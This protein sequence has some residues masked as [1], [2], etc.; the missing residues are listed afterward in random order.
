[1]SIVKKAFAISALSIA[2]L[3]LSANANATDA[4]ST[5]KA[6]ININVEKLDVPTMNISL[7]G[8]P[9]DVI[10]DFGAKK[11]ITIGGQ[12]LN[13]AMHHPAGSF[14]H[15]MMNVA[16]VSPNANHALKNAITNDEVKYDLYLSDAVGS[17]SKFKVYHGGTVS[18]PF[19]ASGSGDDVL[20]DASAFSNAGLS[21]FN[22]ILGGSTTGSVDILASTYVSLESE[23]TTVADGV[24]ADTPSIYIKGTW[25]SSLP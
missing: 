21:E 7:D 22:P 20:N 2:V 12:K 3:G 16:D 17:T 5:S 19:D 23:V 11:F 9:M 6:D 14:S 10:F 15:F 25:G 8:S 18:A 24:F 4:F 13:V 1:M